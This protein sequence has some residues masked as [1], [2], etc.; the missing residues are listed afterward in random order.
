M[1]ITIIKSQIDLEALE[2]VLAAKIKI[3]WFI[4][5]LRTYLPLGHAREDQKLCYHFLALLIRE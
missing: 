2:Y 5:V 3:V 1:V 4:L